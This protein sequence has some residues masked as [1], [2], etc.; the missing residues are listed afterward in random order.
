MA[1]SKHLS[2]IIYKFSLHLFD[3]SFHLIIISAAL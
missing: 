2:A 1:E 3:I